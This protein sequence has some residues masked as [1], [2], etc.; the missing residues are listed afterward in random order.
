MT[1]ARSSRMLLGLVGIELV[2]LQYLLVRQLALAI[3]RPE[4]AA[5]LT[6]LAYFTGISLGYRLSG[7]W[8]RARLVRSLAPFLFVQ[9]ALMAAAPPLG[10]ALIH[11]VGAGLGELV[12]FAVTALGTTSVFSFVLPQLVAEEPEALGGAYAAEVTGSLLAIVALPLLARAGHGLVL[13]AYFAAF[14]AMARLVGARGGAFGAV[15]V[16]SLAGVVAVPRLDPLLS[17]WGYR[18]E[19]GLPN[20]RVIETRFSPYHKIEVLEAAPG[21]KMLVLDGHLQFAPAMHGGY[22]YFLA[23]YPARL[24]GRPSVCVLGCGSLS[25]VGRIGEAAEHITIVDIDRQVFDTSRV[26]FASFHHLDE[27]THWTFQD[28]DAK[29]F[30]AT[31]SEVFDLILHDIPPAR[32]RQVALTYT[33]E[34]FELVRP[35]LALRGVFSLPT[36]VSVSDP[37]R[38]YGRRILATL[39]AVFDQVFVLDFPGAS[40][41]YAANRALTVDE[42][43]L[44]AAID[45]PGRERA[46]ILLDADVRRLVA[47]T[48]PVEAFATH[49]LIE[50]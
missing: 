11:A 29:H 10:R 21:E 18:R 31:S 41:C 50:D 23:E 39:A 32:S 36:L 2:L 9:A 22:S 3:P 49:T 4:T 26:H 48:A 34:F 44:R 45:H 33:R 8:D 37:E 19:S 14:V 42:P 43:M 24:L 25:S 5:I 20:L 13:A 40:Y 35:R 47:G 12:V 17:A 46:R 27:R 38:A 7:R 30:L 1:L 16:V 15:L 6:A 28:D